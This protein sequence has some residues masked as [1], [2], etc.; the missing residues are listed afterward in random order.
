MIHRYLTIFSLLS[1]FLP[2]WADAQETD[3][4]GAFAQRVDVTAYQGRSFRLQAAVKVELIDTTAEAEL[5]ARVDKKDKRVGFFYNMMD[6]PIRKADWQ[7]YTIEGQIDQDAESLMF[8]G[9]YSRQ[10]RF[11]F[12][13]FQ[14]SIASESGEFEAVAVPM[15]DFE[16]DSLAKHWG[17]LQQRDGFRLT[18]TPMAPYRGQQA[19]LVDGSAF[20]K[21]AAHGDNGR[22]GKFAD[23]NGVNLY[24]EEYGQGEPLLLLHGNSQSIAAFAHQLPEFSKDYRVIAVDT[25]GQGKSTEDGQRY[26]YELFAKD[27]KALL[28][29]LGLDSLNVVGWSDG[30]NTGLIMA[31]KYP[32]KV[33]RLVTMGANVYMD[34]SV[35]DRRVVKEIEKRVQDYRAD[36]TRKAQNTVRLMQLL[37]SEPNRVY[38]D[39]RV[40]RCPVLVMAG[41]NDIIKA[42]H[43]RGIAAHIPN[44]TLYIAPGEDHYF[45]MNNPAEF[46][47]VVREFL[48]R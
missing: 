6:K 14:L 23:V 39:L 16:G 46:N 34:N 7:V 41:E 27:M 28:D 44:S 47:R 36:T 5:W 18:T 15:G 4:W 35:V 10:G 33:K 38:D 11:Y 12:D 22:A 25:R 30:G 21:A 45:P 19:A 43:T 32:E 26:T 20:Q 9:L 29:K 42:A 31:M 48:A 17:Y 3:D 8:G 13:D 2:A 37:L 40:I 1:F 24:Y